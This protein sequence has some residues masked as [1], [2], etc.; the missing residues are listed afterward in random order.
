MIPRCTRQISANRAAGRRPSARPCSQGRSPRGCAPSVPLLRSSATEQRCACRP[1]PP[2]RRVRRARRSSPR[3]FAPVLRLPVK[4]RLAGGRDNEP[5]HRRSTWPCACAQTNPRGGPAYAG[6]WA[7]GFHAT[8]RK[9][10]EPRF[11]ERWSL[12]YEPCSEPE[13]NTAAGFCPA[14]APLGVPVN[15]AA[16]PIPSISSQRG[17]EE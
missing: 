17:Q 8:P 16:V 11:A 1:R 9:E 13:A 5:G 3:P 7:S 6:A 4:E 2:L 12:H 10:E 14:V 15:P